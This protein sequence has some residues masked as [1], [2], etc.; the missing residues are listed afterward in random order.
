VAA[1]DASQSALGRRAPVS[2]AGL[3][4]PVARDRVIHAACLL[5]CARRAGAALRARLARHRVESRELNRIGMALMMEPDRADLLRQIV[6]QGK[7][8]TQSDSGALL[9]T[10]TDEHDVERLRPVL[11]EFDFLPELRVP[12]TTYPIDDTS[13]PG[14]AAST[15]ETIVVDD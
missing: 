4:D 8:L 13:V 9:L 3:D 6:R 7:R 10:E 15:G 5:A 11:W 12:P 14:F 1:D 2:I